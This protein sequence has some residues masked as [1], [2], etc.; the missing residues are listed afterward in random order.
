MNTVLWN[1]IQLLFPEEVE[2]RKAAGA[3]NSREAKRQSPEKEFF[4]SLSNRRTQVTIPSS[5]DVTARRRRA[6]PIV[7]VDDGPGGELYVRRRSILR[8]SR[9]SSRRGTV[10]QDEDAALALRMQRE[11]FMEAFDGQSPIRRSLSMARANLRAMA[12]RAVNLR[13]RGRQI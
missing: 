3:L 9:S 12:S 10:D 2:A 13:V 1:T 5:R 8:P 7:D 4:N 11:E 6:I